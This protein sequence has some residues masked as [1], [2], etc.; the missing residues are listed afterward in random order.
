MSGPRV[1]AEHV[2]AVRL[3]AGANCSSIGSVLELVF[4]ASAVSAAAYVAVA[5]ALTPREER[6]GEGASDETP[7]DS[8]GAPQHEE[9][10]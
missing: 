5:A 8:A 4:A 1:A 6:D 2:R 7:P 3:G 9:D 10:R